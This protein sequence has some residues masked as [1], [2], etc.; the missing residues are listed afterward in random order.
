MNGPF[1][2]K[3][4]NAMELI[5]QLE[6]KV[7]A[8]NDEIKILKSEM[9]KY[10]RLYLK[11]AYLQPYGALAVGFGSGMVIGGGVVYWLFHWFK[12]YCL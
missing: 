2:N 1:D 3:A 8:K 11:G 4:V 7:R 5:T 12:G 9:D 6:T 10:M